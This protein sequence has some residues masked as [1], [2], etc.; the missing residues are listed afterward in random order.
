[1]RQ[2]RSKGDRVFKL[3]M[4]Y[5][6]GKVTYLRCYSRRDVARQRDRAEKAGAQVTVLHLAGAR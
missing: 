5:K 1:M 2:T 6:G 3:K 4:V